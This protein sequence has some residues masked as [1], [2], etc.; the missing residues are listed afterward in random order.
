MSAIRC[1]RAAGGGASDQARHQRVSVIAGVSQLRTARRAWGP[2]GAGGVA[3]R[4][5]GCWGWLVLPPLEAA[6][7]CRPGWGRGGEPC[8]PAEG[9]GGD[10][11]GLAAAGGDGGD[12]LEDGPPQ[13][14]SILPV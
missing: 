5:Q 10:D 12:G 4:V 2:L 7:P 14:G 6:V 8:V 11:Q 9:R 13:L 1:G 3:W